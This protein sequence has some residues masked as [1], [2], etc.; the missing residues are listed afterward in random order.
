M[1]FS[2]AFHL[3]FPLWRLQNVP[4]HT[5]FRD[6]CI[7]RQLWWGHRVPAYYVTLKNASSRGST[8]DDHY[9]VCGRNEEEALQRAVKRFNVPKDQ[10]TLSQDEDVLDT[11]FS[12]GCFPF[13][14]LG[15]PE[16]ASQGFFVLFILNS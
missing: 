13:T 8:T 7:S 12:S 3:N 2:F 1:K 11:W 5:Y 9:W 14:M 10:I 15:W 6:W 4:F 16:K